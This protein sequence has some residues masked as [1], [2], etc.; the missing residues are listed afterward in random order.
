[1]L[2]LVFSRLDEF[3]ASKLESHFTEEEIGDAVWELN[4]Q[5]LEHS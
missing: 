2:G 4:Q 3:E 5:E 1:M